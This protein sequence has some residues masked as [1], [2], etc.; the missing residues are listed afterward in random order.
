MH[1]TKRTYRIS[2]LFII[3]LAGLFV[4]GFSPA[5]AAGK[6]QAV[7]DGNAVGEAEKEPKPTPKP[8]PTP[9][10]TYKPIR[11]VRIAIPNAEQKEVY[12]K[13][14]KAQ[15]KQIAKVNKTLQS[16]KNKLSAYQQ[17]QADTETNGS[18]F[19]STG[20][21]NSVL[22]IAGFD[23]YLSSLADY[24]QV[25][26]FDSFMKKRE[27]MV[28][29]DEELLEN[30]SISSP[31]EDSPIALLGA[32][33]YDAAD[34]A[35]YLSFMM[36]EKDKSITALKKNLKTYQTMV[37]HIRQAEKK[38]EGIVFNSTDVTEVSNISV[39]QMK[40]LLAGTELEQYAKVYVNIEKKYGI[41]AIAFCALSALESNWGTSR[42]A[43]KDHNYT[44]FGVYT[45]KSPGINAASGKENLMM[46]AEHL[47]THY[48]HEGDMYYNGT[49]LDGLNQKY[50]ASKTWAFGIESIGIRLMKKLL[51]DE[52][53]QNAINEQ[54]TKTAAV[55]NKT[56]KS[57]AKK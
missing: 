9:E 53:T 47:Y 56:K 10:P 42:R 29:Q 37:K 57:K 49:G 54:S 11:K 30:Q 23:A 6:A 19:V 34:I 45:D 25:G 36:Y 22:S 52:L 21:G 20:E 39:K 31:G 48:I 40:K 7:S 3:A 27:D 55:A 14:I 43:V 44:G 51:D 41:N 13:N 18:L 46:T 24:E 17:I 50:A 8:S 32:K 26:D 2:L 33:G 35:V 28:I 5:K 12:K 1:R 38:D 15:K 16:E 4:I